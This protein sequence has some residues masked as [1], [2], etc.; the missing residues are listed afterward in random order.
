[1]NTTLVGTSA[2]RWE[3]S[4]SQTVSVRAGGTTYATVTFAQ[5]TA[6]PAPGTPPPGGNPPYTGRISNVGPHLE[7]IYARGLAM[8][9][10]PNSFTKVGDCE[11]EFKWFLQ[12]FDSGVYDL[13][14]YQYLAPVITQFR[15]SF[16]HKGQVANAGMSSSAIF[17][18]FWALSTCNDGETPLSCEYRLHRPS[19]ALIMLRTIDANSVAG[20]KFY[21]EVQ[22]AVDDSIN[23]GVIPVLQTMPYWGT[24]NPNT[25]SINAVIRRVAA[26][27]NV[28]LWDYVITSDQLANRGVTVDYHIQ[29][30]A[31]GSGATLFTADRMSD[32]ATRRNLEALEVL[33]AILTQI[34]Q[35]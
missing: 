24:Q 27:K 13:G 12:D 28:P 10:S 31:D 7:T 32:A 9:K 14:A 1:L 21:G 15:G 30:P 3:A 8:G 11:M 20:G 16:L 23:A 4:K 5:V 29:H 2:S 26:E 33:H 6:S 35:N 19:I 25:E 34:I 17:E 22:R 18:D